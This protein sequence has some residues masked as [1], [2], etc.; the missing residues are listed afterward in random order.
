MGH[1]KNNVLYISME[2]KTDTGS[3]ITPL[4]RASF[5]Y[6]IMLDLRW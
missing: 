3:M 1:S 5:S 4:D 6:K 2:I